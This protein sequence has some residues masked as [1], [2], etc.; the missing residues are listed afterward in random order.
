MH[1]YMYMY[2]YST[3]HILLIS[4]CTSSSC[5]NMMVGAGGGEELHAALLHQVHR[6]RERPIPGSNSVRKRGRHGG[7]Q[8]CQPRQGQRYHPLVSSLHPRH[9]RNLN[10]KLNH[11]SSNLYESPTASNIG[12]KTHTSG[13]DCRHGVRQLRTGW[14]DGPAYITQ[15]PIQPGQSYVY[16]FTLAGQ[17]GT[18][19]W[20]AHISWQRA[21]VHGAIVILPKRGVA[22]PFFPTPHKEVVLVLGNHS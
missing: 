14:A 21:T 13:V 2:V 8:G 15:C 6:H 11:C 20:H 10:C 18:L 1:A 17:R 7:G 22:Y 5:F 4:P 16:N 9:R 3:V 12:S 19:L